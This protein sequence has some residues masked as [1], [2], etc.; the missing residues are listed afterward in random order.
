MPRASLERVE[1]VLRETALLESLP[2]DE[3]SKLASHGRMVHFEAGELVFGKGTQGTH[4]YWVVNGRIKVIATARN[5]SELLLKMVEVGDYC[6][7][8]SA[9]ERGVRSSNAIADCATDAVA[10]ESRYLAPAIERCPGA[11][12][13]VV[14]IL[15]GYLRQAVTNIETLALNG[16]EARIWCRLVDLSYRYPDVDPAASTIR[17]QHGLSQ[18][19]LT[20]SVGLTRVMVNRQLNEWREKGLIEYG[21]GVVVIRDT[22]AF[23][24]F[25]WR[26]PN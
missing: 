16:A 20:D 11:A 13:D 12:M 22:A 4:A 25:V 7:E 2:D 3:I 26:V 9:I 21:R 10:L 6:G 24:A 1:S 15:C 19:G 5:G 18:Q 23:E 17:I 14:R 8:I